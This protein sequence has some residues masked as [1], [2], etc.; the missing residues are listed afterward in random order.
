MGQ[1]ASMRAPE[2][3]DPHARLPSPEAMEAFGAGLAALIRPGE[4]V[5]LFGPLGA[6]KSTVA[7][8]LIR[9]LTDPAEEVPSPT[10]TLV[11][12]YE[13]R[14]FPIAHFDL[15]RLKGAQEA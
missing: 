3:Q 14:R 11:Q 4:A 8:G 6:G 13:G 15:Y 9:A 12:T 1:G 2:R 5:C 7:R 10:F